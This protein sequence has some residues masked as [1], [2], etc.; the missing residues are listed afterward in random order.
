MERTSLDRLTSLANDQTGGTPLYVHRWLEELHYREILSFNVHTGNWVFQEPVHYLW[1]NTREV[2]EFLIRVF[3]SLKPQE[4]RILE[5]ASCFTS[6]IDAEVLA[7]AGKFSKEEV[8]HWLPGLIQRGL[9]EQVQGDSYRFSHDTLR[10]IASALLEEPDR[11]KIHILLARTI[12]KKT[13]LMKDK[14]IRVAEQYARCLSLVDS[15]EERIFV[16]ELELQVSQSMKATGD[17]QAAW[18]FIEAAFKVQKDSDWNIRYSSSLMLY[19]E[20]MELA[21]L[22]HK[23]EVQQALAQELLRK[24]SS[25]LDILPVYELQIEE[26]MAQHKLQEAADLCLDLL[27]RLGISE[28]PITTLG[29]AYGQL[30]LL[31]HS[32]WAT[33]V[34]PLF[35]RKR[36]RLKAQEKDRAE[37]VVRVFSRGLT[38]V[39]LARGDRLP[40]ILQNLTLQ[41]SKVE[42]SPYYPLILVLRGLYEG[43]YRHRILA[44]YRYG[45]KALRWA[46]QPE[47]FFL[48]AKVQFIFYFMIFHWKHSLR[49][50]YPNL[51]KGFETGLLGGDWQYASMGLAVATF[52]RV[53][54]QISL[55]K[56]EKELSGDYDRLLLLHEARPEQTFR[57]HRQVGYNFLVIQPDYPWVFSE[58]YFNEAQEMEAIRKAGDLSAYYTMQGAKIILAVHFNAVSLVEADFPEDFSWRPYL[59][60]LNPEGMLLWYQTLYLL[61]SLPQQKAERKAEVYSLVRKALKELIWRARH[62]PVDYWHRRL[63]LQAELSSSRGFEHQAERYYR[64]ACKVAEQNANYPEQALLQET[65]GRFLLSRG[66]NG[67]AKEYLDK[68]RNLY[69]QWG[70]EAKVRVLDAEFALQTSLISDAPSQVTPLEDA[71]SEVDALMTAGRSLS[72]EIRLESLLEKILSLLVRFGGAEYGYLEYTVEQQIKV[73]EARIV[74]RNIHA[75]VYEKHKLDQDPDKEKDTGDLEEDPLRQGIVAFMQ[76]RGEEVIVQ[77][78]SMDPLFSTF[79]TPGKPAKAVFCT[80]L[81]RDELPVGYVYLTNNWIPGAFTPNRLRVLRILL[82]QARVSLEN[83]VFYLARRELAE[84]R[85]RLLRSEKLAS[86]GILTATVAHEVNNPNHVIRLHAEVLKKS[87]SQLKALSGRSSEEVSS[88]LLSLSIE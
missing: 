74:S 56:L 43:A 33:L 52:S 13:P 49:E 22:L 23:T 57:R 78:A 70:A 6:S 63:F 75:R 69:V 4:Q 83:A 9:L 86:L 12:Q 26:Y 58:P 73:V 32:A 65:L 88:K 67:E 11:Q 25:F 30:R 7:E 16:G 17:F 80:A 82:A 66:R 53:F 2:N 47:C 44:G 54:Y 72:G 18:I 41:F 45:E 27:S 39:Y 37:A 10:E 34:Q 55:K 31:L 20:G 81:V 19:R 3:R 51:L 29:A 87:S 84:Q 40:H 28:K 59:V 36:E 64:K 60:S 46:N 76:R 35:F 68:A 24:G 71:R 38:P 48:K 5:L 62:C 1:P 42:D 8:L 85:E 14:P 79:V 50:A 77:D 15:E 61:R 21:F